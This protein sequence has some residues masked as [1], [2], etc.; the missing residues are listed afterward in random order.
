YLYPSYAT[1]KVLA[2]REGTDSQDVE[3]WL[4]YWCVVGAFVAVETG[5][6]WLVDW[7]VVPFYSSI[8]MLLLIALTQGGTSILYKGFLEPFYTQYEPQ[9]DAHLAQLRTRSTAYFQEQFQSIY[10][11]VLGSTAAAQNDP[12]PPPPPQSF[13]AG[14]AS[15]ATGLWNQYGQGALAAASARM[16]H[17][18]E[19]AASGI[20]PDMGQDHSRPQ[21]G[22]FSSS[23][24]AS[25]ASG[26]DMRSPAFPVPYGT[27]SGGASG[28]S[29]PLTPDT[30]GQARRSPSPSAHPY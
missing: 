3:K 7:Y 4:T 18:R 24:P 11:M 13:A 23:R 29:I 16:A 30:T 26:V 8:K 17:P 25:Y 10:K 28:Y 15:V 21:S 22:Q 14:A 6:E 19:A 9:I 20:V 1:F 2:R 5:F 12:P 27:P